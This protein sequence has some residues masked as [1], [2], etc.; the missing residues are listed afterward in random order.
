MV[1]RRNAC[2][3][4]VRDEISTDFS[5]SFVYITFFLER[6]WIIREVIS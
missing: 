4:P 2:I 1:V 6:R 5:L 3:M